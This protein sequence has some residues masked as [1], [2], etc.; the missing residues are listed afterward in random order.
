[1]STDRQRACDRVAGFTLIEALV[2][3]ALMAMILVALATITGQWM[4]NWNRGINR[5]QGDDDLALGLDRL[6]ADLAAAEFIPASAQTPQPL[7][8]G[9]SQSVVLVRTALSPNAHAGLDIVR[10]SETNTASGPMLV[11]T[12][13]PFIPDVEGSRR[14]QPDFTDPVTLVYAPY[15]IWFAYAGADRVWRDSWQDQALLPR[16][17]RLTVRDATTRRAL[18]VSTATLLHVAIPA[19]C[20]RAKSLA[21][22]RTSPLPR[23][24]AAAPGNVSGSAHSQ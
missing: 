14:A 4:P 1:M 21:D 12:R 7:F 13:A 16:A 2:A 15:R 3:T 6:V 24:N 18:A 20:I 9:S 22:C 17:V 23:G 11:R 5:V 8:N 19:F 10:F